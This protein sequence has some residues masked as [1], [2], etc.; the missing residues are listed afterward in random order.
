MEVQFYQG[1]DGPLAGGQRVGRARCRPARLG[2][3]SRR[4]YSAKLPRRP[5][6][7]AD[8]I[9]PLGKYIAMAVRP[10]SLEHALLKHLRPTKAT[11][12]HLMDNKNQKSDQQGQG[13]KQNQGGQQ[14]QGGEKE[15]QG[16]GQGQ[17]G[18]QGGGKQQGS[19]KN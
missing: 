13:D 12:V 6:F 2:A 11:G 17:G 10:F 8:H 15:K 16:G 9:V 14:G 1:P 5:P 4:Q 7:P 3:G 18:Q 19:Q